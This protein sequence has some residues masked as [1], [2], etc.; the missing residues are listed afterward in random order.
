MSKKV[1]MMFGWV[2]IFSIVVPG[3]WCF[4]AEKEPINIGL[5]GALSAPYGVTDKT[6]LEISIE[7]LNKEGGILGRPVKL[8]V[9]D[10]KREVPLAVAAYKKLVMTDKCLAVFTEGTE[11]TTACMQEA[12]RLY[13]EFPH[14]EFGFWTA[15]EGLTD[16][17]C[18]QY[19]KYK[20]FFRV[21][22]KTGDTFDPKLANWNLFQKVIGTKKMALVIEDIGWTQP[23]T[24]GVPGKHLPLK[25]F[26]EEK[27]LKIV[28]YAKSAVAEKMFLPIF[29]KIAASGAD[30]IHWITGY[31]DTITMAKQWAESAAKDL[32]IVAF[33]GACSYAAFW[34]MTG[35]AALGWV[36]LDPEVPIPFTDKTAPFLKELKNRGAGVVSSAYGAYDGPWIIKA[37]V[38]KVGHTQDVGALIKALESVELK[39]GFWTWKFDTCHDPVK[40]YPYYP[41][42]FGE[43]QRDGNYVCIFP[44]ELRKMANPKEKY[45][46][47]KELRA[48]AVQR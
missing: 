11:G 8:I 40:G 6:A 10:W 22:S 42:I 43:F 36:S 38:E 9:E 7:E 25:E 14:L 35:G 16:P 5:I 21:Y 45:V 41:T 20:F 19:D 17:V 18:A 27:G 24:K 33:S 32:D 26:Y 46:H 34:K 44:E 4:S 28:Y 48:K 1:F 30:T 23:Y 37:A 29:E 2:L 31:S 47:V 12:S 13:P 3:N 39:H 15:H